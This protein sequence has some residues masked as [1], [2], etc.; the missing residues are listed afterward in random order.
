MNEERFNWIEVL[1]D[2]NGVPHSTDPPTFACVVCGVVS[3]HSEVW[4]DACPICEIARQAAIKLP[5]KEA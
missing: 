2:V 5:E 1:V 3:Q 4:G